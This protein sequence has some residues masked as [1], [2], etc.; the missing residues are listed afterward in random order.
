VA[1]RVAVSVSGGLLT[2]VVAGLYSAFGVTLP[3]AIA[4]RAENPQYTDPTLL[5]P[6][7]FVFGFLAGAAAGLAAGALIAYLW[8][9][10]NGPKD[11]SVLYFTGTSLFCF[12]LLIFGPWLVIYV[13]NGSISTLSTVFLAFTL[14]VCALIVGYV[15]RKASPKTFE[16]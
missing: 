12:L 6:L 2:G 7:Y 14:V 13:S 16:R 15:A 1:S 4:Q 3:F 8:T 11:R 10:R 9:R 5:W